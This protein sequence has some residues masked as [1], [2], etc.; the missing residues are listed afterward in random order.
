MSKMS[1][2]SK[3]LQIGNQCCYLTTWGSIRL[4]VLTKLINKD[5]AQNF[6]LFMPSSQGLSEERT[7]G[8]NKL[9]RWTLVRQTTKL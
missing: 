6:T 4:R 8:S 1:T 7:K 3:S 9:H 2:L 5:L